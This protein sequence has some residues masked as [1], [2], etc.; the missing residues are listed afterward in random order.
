MAQFRERIAEFD[1]SEQRLLVTRE[2]TASNARLLTLAVVLFGILS[3]AMTSIVVFASN[4]AYILDLRERADALIR[5]TQQRKEAEGFLV[6]AQKM[7]SVG[8]LAGGIA[9]DFNNLL[10][11]VIGGLDTLDRRSKSMEAIPAA[12]VVGPVATA[13]QGARRA[14]ALTQRLLAFSRQQPLAPQKLNLNAIVS[15]ISELLTRTVG[16]TV[17]IETVLAGG[18]WATFV[19]PGQIENALI[20]LVVNARDAMPDGGLVSIETTNANLDDAY[21]A[22]FGDVAAGQYVLLSVTD[23][24]TGIPAKILPNVFD[25]FFTTKRDGKGSGLG[26]AMIHGFVKQSNGHIRIYSE[27]GHGTTVKIYLPRAQGVASVPASP[28]IGARATLPALRAVPGEV[29]LLVEDDDGVHDFAVSSLE[30]LGYL[31]VA[32]KDGAQA[33]ARLARGER[34]DLLFTDVVL[35]NG[36]NGRQL[37]EHAVANRPALPILFTTGYT[38]NA[39]VHNGRLDADVRL[40]SKPYTQVD[41]ARSIRFAL[42]AA[43]RV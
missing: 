8:Q 43:V 27:F 31:V 28:A 26:L 5:E 30:E 14:A 21:A 9:H 37:A 33:L 24:G 12:L 6:Q 39:I 13:L 35:P 4:A 36:M 2:A 11:V 40:L 25:P 32:T 3:A 17:R 18:L 10:T 15:G 41:L 29:V 20:N 19:D 23:T 34:I 1:D 7:E 38:R 16:E 42:D 22:Q